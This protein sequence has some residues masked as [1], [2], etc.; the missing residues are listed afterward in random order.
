M[1]FLLARAPYSIHPALPPDGHGTSSEA[2]QHWAPSDGQVYATSAFMKRWVPSIYRWA[3]VLTALCVSRRFSRLLHTSRLE[4]TRVMSELATHATTQAPP[5]QHIPCQQHDGVHGAGGLKCT[6]QRQ[7]Q[8]QDRGNTR[9]KQHSANPVHN[10][11]R[12]AAAV[13]VA[14][15]AAVGSGPCRAAPGGLLVQDM[16]CPLHLASTAVL[17]APH[18]LTHS[19]HPALH[20]SKAATVLHWRRATTHRPHYSIWKAYQARTS[21]AS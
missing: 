21:G 1:T 6:P 18:E 8:Q 12:S 3:A 20:L 16:L 17:P 14:T 13:I 9:S 11:G 15:P 7:Q 19:S 5:P 4:A 10:G 2:Q